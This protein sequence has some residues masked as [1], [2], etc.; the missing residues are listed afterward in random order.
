MAQNGFLATE[1]TVESLYEAIQQYA[2][3]RLALP[4]FSSIVIP[5]HD[6]LLAM[7]GAF[8]IAYPTPSIPSAASSALAPTTSEETEGF[9]SFF[10]GSTSTTSTN[11]GIMSLGTTMTVSV[12]DAFSNLG[13]VDNAPLP[14][15]DEIHRRNQDL[16]TNETSS[17][18]SPSTMNETEEDEFGEFETVS[19][20]LDGDQP[21]EQQGGISF[22]EPTSSIGGM[23][24]DSFLGQGGGGENFITTNDGMMGFISDQPGSTTL[25]GGQ[26]FPLPPVVSTAPSLDGT[27]MSYNQYGPTGDLPAVS[28]MDSVLQGT[29]DDD[30]FGDFAQGESLP[31]PTMEIIV[32]NTTTITTPVAPTPLYEDDDDPFGSIGGGI[33]QPLPSLEDFGSNNPSYLDDSQFIGTTNAIGSPSFEQ[34][35]GAPS[36][37]TMQVTPS[38]DSMMAGPTFDTDRVSSEA[39]HYPD[40]SIGQMPPMMAQDQEVDNED[41]EFG[42]FNELPPAPSSSGISYA[43]AP[44]QVERVIGETLDDSDPFGAITGI[45]DQPLPTLHGPTADIYGDMSTNYADAGVAFQGFGESYPSAFSDGS[46]PSPNPLTPSEETGDDFGGFTSA[47]PTTA[48]MHTDYFQSTQPSKPASSGIMTSMSFDGG[49]PLGQEVPMMNNDLWDFTNF[50]TGGSVPTPVDDDDFGTF[51]EAEQPTSNLSMPPQLF[52]E[53]AS[54]GDAPTSEYDDFGGF[55]S[56]PL[57]SDG[58]TIEVGEFNASERPSP[59]GITMMSPSFDGSVGLGYNNDAVPEP[60]EFGDFSA[61][62]PQEVK[63]SDDDEFGTFPVSRLSSMDQTT[64]VATTSFDVLVQSVTESPFANDQVEGFSAPAGSYQDPFGSLSAEDAQILPLGSF[65]QGED[66]NT[67]ALQFSA[68]PQLNGPD[69]FS[70]VSPDRG[71]ASSTTVQDDFASFQQGAFSENEAFTDDV[72]KMGEGIEPSVVTTLPSATTHEDQ[73]DDDEDE[74]GDFTSFAPA[75]EN[76]IPLSNVQDNV[77]SASDT[78]T[79]DNA[80][81]QDFF[82]SFDEALPLGPSGMTGEPVAL[83][84]IPFESPNQE[85]TNEDDWGDFEDMTATNPSDVRETAPEAPPTDDDWGAA[86]STSLETGRQSVP[87]AT[88]PVESTDDDDWG[89]FENVNVPVPPDPVGVTPSAS[90]VTDDWGAFTSEPAVAEFAAFNTVSTESSKNEVSSDDDWGD[91]EEISKPET[92]ASLQTRIRDLSSTLTRN[93]L[94]KSGRSGEQVDLVECYEVNVETN[95]TLDAAKARAMSDRCI[96]LLE[97][98]SKIDHTSGCTYWSQILEVVRDEVNN[99]REVLQDASRLS[100]TDMGAV[101][102]PLR[103]MIAGLAE[104]VRVARFIVAAIGDLLML[105]TGALLTPDTMK[106]TWCSMAILEVAL[107]IEIGWKSIVE[108]GRSLLLP[109]KEAFDD[110]PTVTEIRTAAYRHHGSVPLCQLTLQPLVPN[111]RPSTQSPVTWGNRE[112]MACSANLLANLCPFYSLTA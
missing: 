47:V 90:P 13:P 109:S 108:I 91:F 8:V 77:V 23:N 81:S 6:N 20:P 40:S 26:G 12:E 41:D 21:Q 18:V 57:G 22:H 99:G 37:D 45:T 111:Q 80:G 29:D 71:V 84:P 85:E 61:A 101:I 105:D 79:T 78:S 62:S 32:E 67:R 53:I 63:A 103:G 5:S 75:S 35:Q 10:G 69:P 82:G 112:F 1:P 106:S 49:T 16:P 94:R 72:A 25:P 76:D 65:A 24:S 55:A 88:A 31:A 33:N 104:C 64:P 97:I 93:L 96:Q 70:E 39:L 107:D 46:V 50:T 110:P 68:D 2:H 83:D 11:G 38:F 74:F 89:D 3:H 86:A 58:P 30:E 28:M 59:T 52:D 7:Y 95:S 4:I 54:P 34:M 66:S 9:G 44:P 27:T 14:S 19:D 43:M 15:L 87:V 60:D 36:I 98:L 100:T 48:D 92:P 102:Q 17:I 73:A 56:A 42:D 51:T